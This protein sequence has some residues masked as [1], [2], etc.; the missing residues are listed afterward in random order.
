MFGE[1]IER[2]S[3]RF[4]AILLALAVI[5][6]LI[7][8][9]YANFYIGIDKVYT[10][11]F[12]IPII[13]AGIWYRRKA[14][15]VALG[16]GLI[17]V[18]ATSIQEG[19][20]DPD[21]ILRFLMF[22]IVAGVVSS[23]ARARERLHSKELQTERAFRRVA[24]DL[25]LVLES[26][27]EGIYTTDIEG[28]CTLINVAGARMLGY[29]TDELSGRKMHQLIHH[30]RANGTPCLPEEC[31]VARSRDTGVGCR[32]LDDIFWRKDG[33]TFPVEY[34][35]YPIVSDETTIGSVV[36]FSDITMRKQAEEARSQLASI[37]ESSED[38]IIGK[39]LD[40]II[41]SWNAGA[42]RIYGYTAREAIGHNISMLA[43]PDIRDEIPAV[44]DR[45]QSG[46]RFEHHETLRRRKDGT[47][48]NVSLTISPIINNTGDIT[49]VSTIARDITENKRV[50]REL[51]DAKAQAEMYNDLLSH[52]I[53]NMN[54]IGIGYLE[55]ALSAPGQDSETRELLEKPLDALRNSSRLIHNV[56][57]LQEIR[58][59]AGRIAPVDICQM[60]DEVRA[61]YSEIKNRNVRIDLTCGNHSKAMANDLLKDVF[62]NIVG[63]AI[64]HSTG[65]VNVGIASEE[66]TVKNK[67]FCK[68]SIE[69][70]GPGI[71]DDLKPKLFTRFQRGNTKAS[72]KGLGLYLVKNL[73]EGYGGEVCVEDRVAGDHTK[74][75]RFVIMLPAPG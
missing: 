58:A 5:V 57:K 52:D 18:I 65:P 70:N 1:I 12:Y 6:C 36:A 53:N 17:Y 49:G 39:T 73:V 48:I 33:T 56:R 15:Y 75:S 16:L 9:F 7:I 67:T 46:G 31:C 25:Q 63:N 10:H 8:I 44:F 21:S 32:V 4:R 13:L 62:T 74:G 54:Q 42:E 41:T 60:L 20:I 24:K 19:F 69:D 45:M 66:I 43:P 72:G 2:I 30:T 68:V 22:L 38:A 14:I 23:L 61:Q 55:L 47:L 3:Q 29:G 37:V 26:T 28:R 40:G 35:S 27:D 34:S 51:Q 71:P 50:E 59:S 11:I 64:K